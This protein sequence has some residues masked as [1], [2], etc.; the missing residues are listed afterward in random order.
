MSI[1][2]LLSLLMAATPSESYK[3]WGI[4]NVRFVSDDIQSVQSHL[5]S[6]ALSSSY[7]TEYDLCLCQF[8]HSVLYL[9][10]WQGS[11]LVFAPLLYAISF[12]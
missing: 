4:I 12:N 1:I 6:S 3:R 11:N 10:Q 9:Q 2:S 7:G 8:T 5:K